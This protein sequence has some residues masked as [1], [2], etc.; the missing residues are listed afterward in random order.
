M[1]VEGIPPTTTQECENVL[2]V[3]DS[4]LEA[5]GGGG[6]QEGS[7]SLLND[8]VWRA[9]RTQQRGALTWTWIPALF[10]LAAPG[11]SRVNTV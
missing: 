4:S 8:P 11:E 1:T 3:P 2:L 5:G 10:A 9:N 6:G 7:A